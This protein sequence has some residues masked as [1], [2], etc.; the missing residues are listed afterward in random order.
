MAVPGVARSR[1]SVSGFTRWGAC[2]PTGVHLVV[3]HRWHGVSGLAGGDRGVIGG[4]DGRVSDGGCG[5]GRG[6]LAAALARRCAVAA[7]DLRPHP[8]KKA[9]ENGLAI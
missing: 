1:G 6:R 5:G 8:A 3:Q 2:Q 7:Q 4:A 9:V